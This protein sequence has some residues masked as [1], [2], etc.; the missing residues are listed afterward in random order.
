MQWFIDTLTR[1]TTL[2]ASFSSVR[3]AESLRI[4]LESHT[5]LTRCHW[6]QQQTKLCMPNYSL[7]YTSRLFSPTLVSSWRG[8]K[9]YS[10][11]VFYKRWRPTVRGA[12]ALPAGIV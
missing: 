12:E 5:L 3:P 2:R 10:D 4:S 11:D 6:L 9:R 8:Q 7:S 1:G